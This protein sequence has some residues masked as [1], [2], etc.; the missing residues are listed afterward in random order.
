MVPICSVFIKNSVIWKL[1]SSGGG[2]KHWLRFMTK[3]TSRKYKSSVW[4][5]RFQISIEIIVPGSG[6]RTLC[7]HWW[8]QLFDFWIHSLFRW[9]NMTIRSRCFWE[10]NKLIAQQVVML[11]DIFR[12]PSLCTYVFIHTQLHYIQTYIQLL[13]KKGV[14]TGPLDSPPPP[15]SLSPI[16]GLALC[17]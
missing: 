1:N 9:V 16:K 2:R 15:S 17:D 11:A 7:S 4:L 14:G 10:G 13:M 5:P 12:P 6:P 8:P 3:S